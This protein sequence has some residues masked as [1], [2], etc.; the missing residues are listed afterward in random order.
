[1]AVT[2]RR[3]VLFI[4]QVCKHVHHPNSKWIWAEGKALIVPASLSP[5]FIPVA[6]FSV[7][8]SDLEL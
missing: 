6:D 3:R 7:T 4:I 1:M 2:V 8:C 5:V